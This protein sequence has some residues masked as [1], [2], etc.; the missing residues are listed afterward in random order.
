MHY[1]YTYIKRICRWKTYTIYIA[2]LYSHPQIKRKYIF[3]LLS[4]V[5]MASFASSASP[6]GLVSCIWPSWARPPYFVHAV[7]LG[8]LSLP[9]D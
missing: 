8:R 9:S 6:Y 7:F 5:C 1:V 4:I 2:H 3:L